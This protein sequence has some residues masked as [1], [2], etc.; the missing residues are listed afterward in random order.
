MS[1]ERLIEEYLNELRA[2]GKSPNTLKNYA[3]HFEKFLTFCGENG[4]SDL[5]NFNNKEVRD[6][7]NFLL[8]RGLS[9][10]SVNTIISALSGFFTYCVEEG[11]MRGNPIT[12]R[13]FV[14]TP[15]RQPAFL[16][17]QELKTLR[18]VFET[19]PGHV[20]F[21]FELMLATGMRIGEALSLRAE[22][23]FVEDGKVFLKVIG[24]GSKERIV[25]VLDREVAKKLVELKRKKGRIFEIEQSTALWWAWRIKKRTGINFR[26]HRLRHTVATTL[27][28]QGVPIDVVQEVLGHASISTTR[29][30]AKTSS[31]AILKLAV[32]LE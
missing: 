23:I 3:K 32:K 11:Y 29:R 6:F 30:Y 9:A 24:K 27:L 25:P 15:R 12:S 22:D 18:E 1:I 31:E 7:R 2:E 21:L 17:E 26:S 28:R 10:S 8:S 5:S 13:A 16:S 20:R 4:I 14:K 19:L